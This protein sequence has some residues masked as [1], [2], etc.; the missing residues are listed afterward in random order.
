MPLLQVPKLHALFSALLVGALH[1][2]L[3]WQVRAFLHSL[4]AGGQPVTEQPGAADQEGRAEGG[5][6]SKRGECIMRIQLSKPYKL[7]LITTQKG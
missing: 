6:V 5:G 1:W 3:D 4:S 7:N 2:P